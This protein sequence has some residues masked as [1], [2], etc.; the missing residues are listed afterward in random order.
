MGIYLSYDEFKHQWKWTG[1]MFV[2]C[3]DT[4][5]EAKANQEKV[6]EK[7]MANLSAF[8]AISDTLASMRY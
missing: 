6:W 8:R 2:M 4:E 5:E 3:F 1:F 7:H